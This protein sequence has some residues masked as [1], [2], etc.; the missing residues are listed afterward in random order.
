MTY[1]Q[2]LEEIGDINSFCKICCNYC[3][4]NDWYCPSECDFLEKARMLDFDRIVKSWAKNNGDYYKV[5]QY[6]KRAK[7]SK[8]EVD[9]YNDKQRMARKF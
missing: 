2:A 4:A 5:F 6:I 8:K 9:I 1:E 3:Q 7:L